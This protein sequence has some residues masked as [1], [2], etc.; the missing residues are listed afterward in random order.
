MKIS[1]EIGIA[2][3]IVLI[4]F[5]LPLCFIA[6]SLTDHNING[7]VGLAGAVRLELGR[8]FVVLTNDPHQILVRDGNFNLFFGEHFDDFEEHTNIKGFGYSDGVRY[9]ARSRPFT[10]RWWIITVEESLA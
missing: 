4:V 10:R 8:D 9:Y 1:K 5:V 2:V 6:I 3:V 7:F